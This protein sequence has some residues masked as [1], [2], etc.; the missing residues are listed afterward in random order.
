[1]LLL[2]KI[3]P[4]EKALK[5]GKT[6]LILQKQPGGLEYVIGQKVFNVNIE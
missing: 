3:N 2:S 5:R 1:M 4:N 6:E